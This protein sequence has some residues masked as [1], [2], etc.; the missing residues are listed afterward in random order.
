MLES[1]YTVG[2]DEIAAVVVDQQAGEWAV[3]QID[4]CLDVEGLTEFVKLLGEVFFAAERAGASLTYP[5]EAFIAGPYDHAA[6][7]RGAL[8]GAMA[9]SGWGLDRAGRITRLPR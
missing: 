4:M 1:Y 9:V 7:W 5:P 3:A 8:I 6:L 2:K